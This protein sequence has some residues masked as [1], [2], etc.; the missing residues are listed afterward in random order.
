MLRQCVDDVIMTPKTGRRSY[1][2]LEKTEKTYIGTRVEIEL[3]AMLNL[4]KGKLDT[5]I[6]GVS[7]DSVIKHDKFVAK[8]DLKIALLSDEDGDVCERYGTWVEK[9]MYGKK[10]MGIERSTFLIDNDGRI[11][12]AW[13]TEPVARV[14]RTSFTNAIISSVLQDPGSTQGK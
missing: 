9:S 11:A 4:P 2:E 8:H 7:K 5:V 14:G 10:F 12:K 6:L 13:N 1:D 3:R